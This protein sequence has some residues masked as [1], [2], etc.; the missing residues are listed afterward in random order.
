MNY[1]R[2]LWLVLA[3]SLF[4]LA[5]QSSAT[6]QDNLIR[7][8]RLG[9]TFISSLD[10]PASEMRY[11][12]A[13]LLGAG[14]NRWP[15]YWD[16]VEK[17]PGQYDWSGYDKL[18]GDDLRHGLRID[19]ILLGRPAFDQQ[20]G[21]IN[22]L[23]SP[24][25]SDG[26]DSPGDGKT[27][28]PSNPWA[29]FVFAVVNRYKAGGLLA[30]QEGWPSNV[31]VTVWEAWNEPDFPL[32]W[33]GSVDDYARL[34]KVTYLVAH[35][36]DP[37]ARVMF[38]GLA[39]SNPAQNDWL[40]KVLAI[41]AKDPMRS[42]SNNFMDLVAVH[43]YSDPRRSGIV[44]KQAKD[45]LARYG[46]DR[47]VWLNES[48]VPVWDDYPGPTWT[49]NDPASRVLRATLA[50]QADF[51]VQSSVYAWAEG[52]DVVF[53][54]QLYDDCGN[55][56][57]GTNFPPN[58]GDLCAN[59]GACWGDAHGLYRNERDAACFSQSPMPGTP[60]PAATA[61]YRLA[62]IF[63][64]IPFGNPQILSLSTDDTLFSFDRPSTGEQILVMW[65]R[66]LIQNVLKVPATAPTSELYSIDNQNWLITPK[67][68]DYQIGLPAATRDDYPYLAPGDVS[69]IGGQPYIMVEKPDNT[70]NPALMQ[71][72]TI[73]P[74]A[75]VGVTPG[76]LTAT[77]PPRPTTDPA[78]DTTPPT[79]SMLAM[80]VISP[81]TFTVYWSGQDD[82]GIKT[83][84]IWVRIDHGDWQPWLQTSATQ[85]QYTG[86]SG[87]TY[88]FA[89]WAQDLAGNWSL[90]TELTPQAITSVQ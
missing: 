55:Q 78:N 52:A 23:N 5:F 56:P 69:A 25:F 53:I 65:N 49:A 82:S 14:W 8:P 30:T 24:V 63:G 89:A 22:G 72:T 21:S 80:S 44:V 75:S 38:G 10:Y 19:A 60:R 67:D 57:S 41:Y 68:G 36:A 73:A 1:L 27:P 35:E 59:G 29:L 16:Q 12:R 20:G 86:S 32:F 54:H 51:V 42:A 26:T 28:N 3:L 61:Y 17:A 4:V 33:N 85:A 76:A 47:P 81:P 83:Y 37:N 58:N 74:D 13:L 70:V 18:V 43:N 2:R 88:E 50:Q 6:A 64:T 90:N 79:T 87:H 34:L 39:Y 11:Q 31:G 46:F 48:G 45:D 7:S 62:Q 77:Q 40:A 9:I 71:V 15:L 84:L 66:S